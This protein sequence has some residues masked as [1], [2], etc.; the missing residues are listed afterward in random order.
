ML[1]TA[2]NLPLH[3]Q[4]SLCI[5]PVFA[6]GIGTVGVFPQFADTAMFQ[7][8][9]VGANPVLGVFFLDFAL[10]DLGIIAVV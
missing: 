10:F 8:L 7:R 1:Q 4:P 2:F 3:R 9:D 6:I 5:A